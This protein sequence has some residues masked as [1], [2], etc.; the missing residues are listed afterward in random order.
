MKRFSNDKTLLLNQIIGDNVRLLR[1]QAKCSQEGLAEQLGVSYQQIQKY[2]KGTNRISACRLWQVSLILNVSI[3]LF[4]M[5]CNKIEEDE[6][7]QP[8]EAETAL[9]TSYRTLSKSDRGRLLTYI[10]TLSNMD[11]LG[12]KIEK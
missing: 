5:G 9:L 11:D 2:E 4:F 3:E 1:L 6:S 8:T 10:D 12:E 7:F